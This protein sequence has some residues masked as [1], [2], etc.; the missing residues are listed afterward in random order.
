MVG[1]NRANLPPM[2][3]DCAEILDLP[4]GPAP[5]QWRRSRRARRVS[6]RIDPRGGTVVVTLPPRAGRA[7]GMALL[8]DH[9]DWVVDRL[10]ALA[11]PLRL[12]DGARIPIGGVPHRVRHCPDQRGGAW[13]AGQEIIVTGDAAFLPRRLTDFLRNEARRRLSARVAA[14]AA[15]AGLSPRRVTVKDTRSRWGSCTPDGVIMFC[16]RLLLAPEPVQDYVV[17]HEVAHLRHLDHGRQFWTLVDTL[18]PHRAAAIAWLH[19]EGPKL[20]RI[21]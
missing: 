19:A 9:A 14:T 6:L 10:A 12:A 8:M 15:R 13:I 5:V 3:P 20:L 1:G 17:A 7:A 16:W 2:L 21:G 4:H 18:S 11:A